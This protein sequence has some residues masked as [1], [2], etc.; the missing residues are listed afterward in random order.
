MNARRARSRTRDPKDKLRSLVRRI[1][2]NIHFKELDETAKVQLPQIAEAI[3]LD[4]STDPFDQSIVWM[5][6]AMY[7]DMQTLASGN[8]GGGG[9][10]RPLNA[11][12]REGDEL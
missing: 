11:R 3:I 12:A 10:M 5:L 7:R 8:R 6:R 9:I 4:Q 1:M 2:G